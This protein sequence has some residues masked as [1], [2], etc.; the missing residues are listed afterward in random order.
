[1]PHTIGA[2]ERLEALLATAVDGIVI[3]DNL[4]SVQVYSPACVRLFGYEAHEVVGRNVNMLMPAPYHAHH[5]GYL[6]HFRTTGE[7]RIIGIGREVVGRRKDGSTF[8]MYLS[9]G[10]G[11]IEGEAMFVGII[12][13]ITNR[14]R[15]EQR[16]A[17]L[18]S[19]L[20]HVTRL[21]AMGE[22]ASALAHELNQPLAANM[23][24]ISAAL[25]M[26]EGAHDP[27]LV[28]ELLTKA[29]AQM[30]RAGQIIRRLR[31]FIEKGQS[32]RT[33][34]D[35]N[36]VI[37]EAL[38]LALVGSTVANVK[39]VRDLAHALPRI[40]I[41]KVQIQQV[42]HNLVRNAIEAMQGCPVARLTISTRGSDEGI[43]VS[44]SDTGAGLAPDV[45][46]KIF[47]P[48]V[49]TKDT[50][51]GIGLSICR[52]IIEAHHGRIWVEPDVAEGA[53]FVFQLPAREG[54]VNGSV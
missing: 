32:V 1:M 23:N 43:V 12:H 35:I 45:L 17:E 11:N 51:M 39:V 48:F 24:Y 18:Q 50:G 42:V 5:D 29:A 31:D 40:S 47:Q 13:D 30:T 19:E 4:G 49:T 21:S 37:E 33:P 8:P 22:M 25:R 15:A 53:R 27:A 16:V 38:G 9:V 44:V 20:L 28:R 46:A 26:S 34:E 52:S 10:E 36:A 6:K 54:A 41:D 3:I 14:H 7:K 2:R